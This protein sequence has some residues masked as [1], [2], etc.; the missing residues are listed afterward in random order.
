MV[1]L[2]KEGHNVVDAQPADR[3]GEVVAS[4]ARLLYNTQVR[5]D[6]LDLLLPRAD[7]QTAAWGEA[8][9]GHSAQAD[10]LMSILSERQ[11][12]GAS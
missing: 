10:A 12:A 8:A 4:V 2:A 5:R 1:N 6:A 7:D 11:L 9:S 3:F